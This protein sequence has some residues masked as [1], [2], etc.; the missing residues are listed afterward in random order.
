MEESG[1][2]AYCFTETTARQ[3]SKLAALR[4][5]DLSGA[6][7]FRGLS[8]RRRGWC[9]ACALRIAGVVP[10]KRTVGRTNATGAA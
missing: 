4:L 2:V 6:A 3:H 8:W 1:R 5:Y 10:A 9:T 7:Y